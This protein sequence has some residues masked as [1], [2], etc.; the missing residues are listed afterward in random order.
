MTDPHEV[1][2]EIV[3]AADPGLDPAVIEEVVRG[4]TVHKPRMRKLAHAL[5]DD[6]G[7]LVSGRPE[8]PKLVAVLI[9]ALLAVGSTRVTR[10]RCAHCGKQN[11]LNS[12]AT[13]TKERICGYCAILQREAVCGSCGRK[14]AVAYRDRCGRPLCQVCPPGDGDGDPV[15]SI[16][17]QLDRLDTGLDG[18][19]LA[20]LITATVPMPAQRQHL[21]WAL[22]ENPAPLTGEGARGTPRL[23]ALLDCLVE[24]GARGVTIPSCLSCGKRRRLKFQ[25]DGLRCCRNCYER[26]RTEP[27]GHCGVAKRI[28]TRGLDGQAVCHTCV[29]R[30]PL[31]FQRCSR[32]G[33]QATPVVN[34][35]RE[36]LC[37][38]CYRPPTATCSG[39]GQGKPCYR[40]STDAPLCE[41][42]M[43]KLRPPETCT[44]CGRARLVSVR[45]ADGGALCHACG[46]RKE[47]CSRC[48]RVM[49]V[50]GR[51]SEGEALCGTCYGRHPVSL[52]NCIRC[53]GFERLHHH[54]LCSNCAARQQLHD[55][56]SDDE[57]VLY[58]AHEP[59]FTALTTSPASRILLWL[60]HAAPRRIL[61]AIGREPQPVTHA[62]LDGLTPPKSANRLRAAL[63]A[64][65]V[66]ADRDERLA[67]LERWLG[68][69]LDD[70]LPDAAERQIVR[71]F[72]TWT[73]MRRLRRGFPERRTTF[74]QA[75][76]VKREV[77]LACHLI[78]WLHAR[79]TSLA[80]CDQADIDQWL[81]DGSTYRHGTRTFVSWAVRRGHAGAIEVPA[82]S[83]AN[84][85]TSFI[86]S[87]ERWSKAKELLHDTT[88]DPVDRV[89]GLLLLLFA[90]PLTRTATI[91]LDLVTQ[92]VS[93]RAVLLHL[94]N[95]PLELPPPLDQLVLDL[96]ERRHGHAVIGR[97]LDMTWL[98]PGGAPGQHLSA[99]QIMRRLKTLGIRARHARNTALMDLA[100]QL[101]ASVLADLLNLDTRTATLWN[102]A[103]G[104]TRS[105]Y[106]AELARRN[107]RR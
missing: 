41:N 48:G 18:D 44:R 58:P 46:R 102:Q 10:P 30:D 91:T 2:A 98:F 76:V 99:R 65:G 40:A 69:F 23:L 79:G 55:L 52:R 57:G 72:V 11:S 70:Q 89:A 45:T 19:R 64:Q 17:A 7:L 32:C 93:D 9:G 61:A 15:D 59:V 24:Q 81:A 54:G 26:A 5:H 14:A 78:A 68:P 103:A 90:Q 20:E 95:K 105:D 49:H 84:L 31:N 73:H 97:T 4:I 104:N 88:L 21:A 3:A 77:R 63:V 82:R 85:R 107:Q 27:C 53:G 22:E 106:A 74:S 51:T 60:S 37:A 28:A 86:D 16:T 75:V 38:S 33:R 35:S 80:D 56:L 71:R 8:G 62:L 43:S 34:N 25:L 67:A 92:R 101:P 1:V 42:C 50:N 66:L 47:E 83:Q 94:G 96:V 6:P 87:D 12:L 36:T 100:A 13:G 29:R 39:C